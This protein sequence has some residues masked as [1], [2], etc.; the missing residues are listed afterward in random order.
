MNA[1]SCLTALEKK[2]LQ[3]KIV[4]ATVGVRRRGAKRRSRARISDLRVLHPH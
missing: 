2:K 3:E 4:V 1:Y